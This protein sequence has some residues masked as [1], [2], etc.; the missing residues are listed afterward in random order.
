M[1]TSIYSPTWQM[2]FSSWM[3]Y[4]Q[5]LTLLMCFHILYKCSLCWLLELPSCN[6]EG[7]IHRFPAR[8]PGL[9]TWRCWLSSRGGFAL[10]CKPPRCVL[11][12]RSCSWHNEKWLGSLLYENNTRWWILTHSEFVWPLCKLWDVLLLLRFCQKYCGEL[13][14]P[15]TA[16]VTRLKS[17]EF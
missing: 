13:H 16:G 9:H 6:P 12:N 7:A 14:E 5:S 1:C 11:D 8:E 2:C 4:E 17:E 3:M 10:S 15:I